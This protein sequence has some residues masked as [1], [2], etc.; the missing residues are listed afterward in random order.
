M[1]ED[2]EG[3]IED[4]N[5][6]KEPEEPKE[7]KK[8]KSEGGRFQQYVIGSRIFIYVLS[9]LA[10]IYL[11]DILLG[12]FKVHESLYTEN[13]LET[14]KTLAFTICGYLFGKSDSDLN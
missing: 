2:Q 10:V 1:L 12:V 5:K 7:N 8:G 4:N 3:N 6:D 13:I 9:F 11:V 14:V